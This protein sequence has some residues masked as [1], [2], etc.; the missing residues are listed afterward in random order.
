MGSAELTI[1][2]VCGSWLAGLTIAVDC[3]GL[4]WLGGQQGWRWRWFAVVVG[5]G[6]LATELD[7]GS[8]D[9]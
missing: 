5:D 3:G 9:F 1:A 4:R 8:D 7:G 2:M 6:L